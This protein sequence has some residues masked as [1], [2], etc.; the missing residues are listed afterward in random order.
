[1]FVIIVLILSTGVNIFANSDSFILEKMNVII[2]YGSKMLNFTDQ[3]GN[4]LPFY[5]IMTLL[6][7]RSDHIPS[8]FIKLW[9]ILKVNIKTKS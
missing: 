5:H 4:E 9:S 2:H 1:M 7:F 6:M 3:D 8:N